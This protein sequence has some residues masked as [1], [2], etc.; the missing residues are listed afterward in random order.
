VLLAVRAYVGLGDRHVLI[1]IVNGDGG[2]R[3]VVNGRD[4]R[5]RG[6][7]DGD[8]DVADGDGRGSAVV[9]VKALFTVS[10]GTGNM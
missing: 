10:Y 1:I 4:R 5:G 2:R 9:T 6:L 7:F 8:I 3:V